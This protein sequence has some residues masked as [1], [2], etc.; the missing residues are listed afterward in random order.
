MLTDRTA[1]ALK[2]REKQYEVRAG[3]VAGLMLRVLASGA[4][5]WSF[6]Y[7]VNGRQRRVALG[8]FPAVGIAA[9]RD[10]AED[11]LLAVRRG[12]DPQRER[13]Q[14]READTVKDAASL[15]L[16]LH[17]LGP[18]I[19]PRDEKTG[20]IAD[21]WTFEPESGTPRKRT[22]REDRRKLAVEIIPKWGRR[23]IREITR[24][25][26]R[27]LVEAVA[28]RGSP[29]S[30]NRL[31]AL[32]S[33]LFNVSL[34]RDLIEANPVLATSRPGEEKPRDRV[35]D[36]EEV[37]TLWEAVE[38]FKK[39]AMRA[40]FRLLLLTAQRVGEVRGMRW[41]ELNLD[42]GMW[43]IP[44]ERSKNGKSHR[45]PLT[46]PVVEMIS[47]LP[48][49]DPYVLAGSRGNRQFYLAAT[50]I[51]LDDFQPGRDL[52]STAATIMAAAGVPQL[53]VGH[54]LN[55]SDKSVTARHYVRASYDDEKR[56]ALDTLTRKIT[57]IIE[58]REGAEVVAF[59]RG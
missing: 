57:A 4:K 3:R 59:T 39:P 12:G 9:A 42:N 54:V 1:R 38:T 29:T 46:D 49:F 17:A 14:Q 53:H 30:A 33:K 21:V 51:G 35:L 44:A 7:R 15:F 16:D 22:W 36:D 20:R 24:R 25:D 31:R 28:H 43:T 56:V 34:E 47:G 32:L 45:V 40:M 2:S 26:V 6:R 19:G 37:R 23:P 27:E 18:D 58:R 52:R 5:C 55:H 13:Q 48:Q 41:D 11:H 10:M 8:P 50:E